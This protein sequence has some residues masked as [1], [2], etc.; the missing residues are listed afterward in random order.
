LIPYKETYAALMNEDKE[1]SREALKKLLTNF[2]RISMENAYQKF[3]YMDNKRDK[4]NIMK[5]HVYLD[6]LLVL[7][8][9]PN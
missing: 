9:L 1:A 4:K 5:S 3:E 8:R 6:A 2:V 7:Q